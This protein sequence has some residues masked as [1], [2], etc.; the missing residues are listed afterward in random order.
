MK[1]QLWVRWMRGWCVGLEFNAQDAWI[2]AYW[3]RAQ[4]GARVVVW[5]V[6]V[7][8]VPFFPI[9]VTIVQDI[10]VEGG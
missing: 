6:W 4:L 5:D 3:R 1:R 2:G 10:P 9:H 7:C 8:L